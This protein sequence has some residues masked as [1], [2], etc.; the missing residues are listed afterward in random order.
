MKLS[1]AF[2]ELIVRFFGKRASEIAFAPTDQFFPSTLQMRREEDAFAPTEFQ[3][4]RPSPRARS[5][6]FADTEFD[7]S[8]HPSGS[9]EGKSSTPPAA[10][11][12]IVLD[13]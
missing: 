9:D 4:Y 2:K 7:A 1:L 10:S 13:L 6:G 8:L 12:M 5:Q 3:P 11:G